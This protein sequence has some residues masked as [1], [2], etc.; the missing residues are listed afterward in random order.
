[1]KTSGNKPELVKR[2]HDHK[3]PVPEATAADPLTTP[4]APALVTVTSNLPMG[5]AAAAAAV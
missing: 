1:M 3:A 2:L 5:A 4:V